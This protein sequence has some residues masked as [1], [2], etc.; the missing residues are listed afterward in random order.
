MSDTQP[1]DTRSASGPGPAAAGP[2]R[3]PRRPLL[4]LV[5]ALFFIAFWLASTVV[6]TGY[7]NNVGGFVW[8][9]GI[10]ALPVMVPLYWLVQRLAFRRESVNRHRWRFLGAAC[11]ATA[12]LY[13][14]I[15]WGI[16]SLGMSVI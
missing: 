2:R 14:A 10:I 6:F 11:L 1:R 5:Y 13:P 3:G 4:V 16:A 8:G 12:I 15:A 7:V 9:W